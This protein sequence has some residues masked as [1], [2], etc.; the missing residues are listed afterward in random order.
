MNSILAWLHSIF[1]S[2]P[3][4]WPQGKT[5][6]AIAWAIVGVWFLLH[7]L[8]GRYATRKGQSF[9]FGFFLA[10]LNGPLFG[11][12]FVACLRPVSVGTSARRRRH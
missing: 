6:L 12:I 3:S 4:Q 7:L 2:I 11:A 8:V 1:P 9:W 5:V 10:L